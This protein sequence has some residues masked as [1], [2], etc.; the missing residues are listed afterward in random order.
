[1]LNNT[2]LHNMW[3]KE[4][5]LRQIFKYFE[6]NENAGTTCQNLWLKICSESNIWKNFAY[7]TGCFFL[8]INKIDK[9]L[10]RLTKKKRVDTN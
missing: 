3:V 4:E 2:L 9:P 8:K 1:M 6:L 7:K 10:A 5:I